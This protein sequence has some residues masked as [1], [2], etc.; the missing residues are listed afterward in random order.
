MRQSLLSKTALDSS[1]FFDESFW[2][3]VGVNL[4]T[5]AL[6]FA[7]IRILVGGIRSTDPDNGLL[8]LAWCILGLIFTC[9]F[10]FIYIRQ[11]VLYCH[12]A[13]GGRAG[14]RIAWSDTR[15]HFWTIPATFFLAGLA[16]WA[17]AVLNLVGIYI[18]SCHGS[19]SIWTLPLAISSALGGI[20]GTVVYAAGSAWIYRRFA[21]RLVVIRASDY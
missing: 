15:G 21:S 9:A 1:A 3:Y 7:M 20:I 18:T 16:I 19:T 11:T 8:L 13:V 10:F 5:G 17:F 12:V 6:G 4:L 14:W 2:R